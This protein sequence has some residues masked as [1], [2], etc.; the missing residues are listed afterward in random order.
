[1]NLRDP[2]YYVWSGVLFVLPLFAAT[3][4]LVFLAFRLWLRVRHM[5]SR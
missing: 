4:V 3:V 5:N 1:M 2:N